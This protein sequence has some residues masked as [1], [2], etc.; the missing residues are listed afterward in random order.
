MLWP[1]VFESG[2]E[3]MLDHVSIPVED[4]ERSA[5]FYD[6][7]LATLRYERIKE[8]AGRIGYGPPERPAPVFWIIEIGEGERARPGPGLHISLMATDPAQVDRFHEIALA[9]G[10]QDA[11]PPGDRPQYTRPF[12]GAFVIDPDGYKI[13]AVCR[14]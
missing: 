11:G 10:G 3:F 9:Q 4:L 14:H 13:E 5:A 7:V 12:Y 1:F 2:A 8:R 6:A